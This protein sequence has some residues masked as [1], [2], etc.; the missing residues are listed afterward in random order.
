MSSGP[1][2]Q[3]EID[4]SLMLAQDRSQSIFAVLDE[5][6]TALVD[7]GSGPRLGED[8]PACSS[9]RSL[10]SRPLTICCCR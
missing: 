9:I 8:G 4:L 5:R 3:L 10:S 7:G 1:L 2:D 6:A